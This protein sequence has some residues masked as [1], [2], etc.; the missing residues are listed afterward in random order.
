MQLNCQLYRYLYDNLVKT[1]SISK[2]IILICLTFVMMVSSFGI[3]Q[4]S[5]ICKLALAG[6]EEVA[7]NPSES[8]E[9]P[10]CSTIDVSKESASSEPCCTNTIK[11]FQNK[12]VTVIHEFFTIQDLNV[13][14][15]YLFYNT[16][17]FNLIA[18]ASIAEFSTDFPPEQPSGRFILISNQTF[19]I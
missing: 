8:G 4:V 1:M 11:Y 19:L 2:Q 18:S 7:C 14:Q 12:V 15:V 6:M 3:A 13:A 9:H 10:C 5:H 17:A 16:N